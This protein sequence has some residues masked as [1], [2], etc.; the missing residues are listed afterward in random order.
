[1]P[2][3]IQ[4]LTPLPNDKILKP[5]ADNKF[6]VAEIITVLKRVKNTVGK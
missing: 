6:I 4:I 2:T 1:M 3:E 5:F